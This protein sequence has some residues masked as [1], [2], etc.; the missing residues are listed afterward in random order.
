M[1]SHRLS[2][3]SLDLYRYLLKS[4]TLHQRRN[5][6]SK[7][8]KRRICKLSRFLSVTM[9]IK[10]I[11]IFTENSH[12]QSSLW[13]PVFSGYF[14]SVTLLTTFYFLCSNLPIQ[15][16][17]QKLLLDETLN[18]TSSTQALEFFCCWSWELSIQNRI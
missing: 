12:I 13:S 8:Q 6:I 15:I 1:V 11:K 2:H 7:I 4:T 14:H 18:A 9:Y 3:S 5:I 16:A 17:I 10:L